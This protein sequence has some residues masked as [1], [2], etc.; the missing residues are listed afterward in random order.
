MQWTGY[1]YLSTLHSNNGLGHS[2]AKIYGK[3]TAEILSY[4]EEFTTMFLCK[5]R[6]WNSVSTL[7]SDYLLIK[8]TVAKSDPFLISQIQHELLK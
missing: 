7:S 3:S 8:S 5:K 4:W 1:S 6:I 2:A